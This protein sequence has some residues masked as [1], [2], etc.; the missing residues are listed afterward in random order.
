ML[1]TIRPFLMLL[2]ISLFFIMSTSV[3]AE[4]DKE[5]KDAMH[6]EFDELSESNKNLTVD[7]QAET[8]GTHKVQEKLHDREDSAHT[9]E[10]AKPRD[11]DRA[12][13]TVEEKREVHSDGPRAD[14]AEDSP[15]ET[16]KPV[17]L[18]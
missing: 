10:S 1:A 2:I 13:K 8:L 17:P 18:K 5:K 7:K 15:L 11:Q 12:G 16:Q 4:Y 6:K 3:F 14:P 9:S